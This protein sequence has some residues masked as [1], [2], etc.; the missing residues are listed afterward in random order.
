MRGVPNNFATGS[1]DWVHADEYQDVNFAQYTW[2]KMLAL[3]GKRLFAVG[4]DDQ[5]ILEVIWNAS[6]S[7]RIRRPDFMRPD[8]ARGAHVRDFAWLEFFGRDIHS[9]LLTREVALGCPCSTI[10]GGR[11][12]PS[13][14]MVAAS[15]N[16]CVSAKRS[17]LM[18]PTQRLS[19]CRYL[20]AIS[21]VRRKPSPV[22]L[23]RSAMRPSSSGSPP[24]GFGTIIWSIKACANAIL[25]PAVV[26]PHYAAA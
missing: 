13:T 21:V 26:S 7:R 15:T 5:S 11:R 24:F 22:R 3:H 12:P 18:P 17:A 23:R 10:L 14:P 25:C 9:C 2:L 1:F 6:P 4:D 8:G 16:I 20:S 19:T